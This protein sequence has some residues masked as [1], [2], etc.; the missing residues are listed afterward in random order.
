MHGADPAQIDGLRT[1]LVPTHHGRVPIIVDR[2]TPAYRALILEIERRR[3]FLGWTCWQLEDAAGL[4]D[5]HYSHLLQVD[6]P[7]GRQGTW[8]MVQLLIEAMYPEGFDL[9][10]KP[11]AGETLTAERHALKVKFAAADHDRKSRRALMRALGKR[12][13]QAR[14]AKYCAM[15]A[16]ERRAIVEK[17]RKTK[18]ANRLLREQ[19]KA[20]RISSGA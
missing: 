2:A 18:R 16:A 14:A 20:A 17:A 11:K 4:N 3:Q 7:S 10:L 9:I 1:A 19:A 8:K 13:G 5:G 6:R 12:G 15:S